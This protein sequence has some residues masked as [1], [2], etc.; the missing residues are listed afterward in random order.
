MAGH[1]HSGPDLVRRVGF[2]EMSVS[3]AKRL[4]EFFRR[5]NDAPAAHSAEEALDLI[6]A[7]LN[8][9]EDDFTDIPFDP[10]KWQSDGRMYPPQP[11]SRRQVPDWPSVTRYRSRNHNT[12]IA[13]NGAIEIVEVNGPV[14]LRKAGADGK[15]LWEK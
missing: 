9:T 5:L 7:T 6:A 13:A 11:D 10:E 1:H 12:F 4:L 15:H 8:S 2:C 3:K 14:I